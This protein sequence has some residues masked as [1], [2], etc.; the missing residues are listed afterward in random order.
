MTPGARRW[1]VVSGA[2]LAVGLGAACASDPPQDESDKV[3]MRDG[4]QVG[5]QDDEDHCRAA[6]TL[7]SDFNLCMMSRGWRL[8]TP[9][10]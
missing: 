3:W 1:L 7:Q 8:Q 5:L 2:T 4:G 9:Q 6:A 10:P